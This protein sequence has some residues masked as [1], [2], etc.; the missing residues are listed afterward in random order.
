MRPTYAQHRRLLQLIGSSSP[1]RRWLLKY[2]VHMRNLRTVLHTYPDACF[3]H[4]HR[5]PAKVLPSL[6]SLV[7]GWRAI[8]EGE[9][10]RSAL[11]RWQMEVWAAGMEHAIEVRKETDSSR[12]YD[13]SFAEVVSDPVAAVKRIYARFDVPLTEDSERRLRA[14]REHNPRGKYGEHHYSVEDFGLTTSMIHDRYAAYL[15][16]F[17]IE[18]EAA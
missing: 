1:T 3:I 5:D 6:C 17:A 2:P 12:F 15:D 14:W 9:V 4:C 16:H 10:D 7:A 8:S 13:L 18:R 11:A